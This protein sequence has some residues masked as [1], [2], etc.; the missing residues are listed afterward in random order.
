LS[1]DKFIG[2]PRRQHDTSGVPPLDASYNGRE[3]MSKAQ[4][5]S[6]SVML[7]AEQKWLRIYRTFSIC[8]QNHSLSA[9]KIILY[10]LAKPFPICLQSN[11][12]ACMIAPYGL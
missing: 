4:A 8:L 10:L 11:L 2:R 3:D 7:A 6:T 9:C 12:S 1:H 5:T